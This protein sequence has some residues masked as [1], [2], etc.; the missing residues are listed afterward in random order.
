MKQRAKELKMRY[1]L[2]QSE[3]GVMIE[4]FESIL[5]AFSAL[6]RHELE[7]RINDEYSADW[8]QVYDSERCHAVDEYISI[9]SSDIE[10]E[11]FVEWI[12]QNTQFTATLSRNGVAENQIS[13]E[14]WPVYRGLK[15]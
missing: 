3:C 8:Y 13:N 5:D 14:L 11:Q 6:W 9:D 15:K 4:C 12:N 10:A 2:R 1:E 7:D